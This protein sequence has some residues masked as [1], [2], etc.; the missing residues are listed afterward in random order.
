VGGS[1]V[2]RA[3]VSLDAVLRRPVLSAVD[4]ES[5]VQRNWGVDGRAEALPGERDRNFLVT[6]GDGRRYVLKVAGSEEDPAVI[7]CQV[8][9]VERLS[10]LTSYQWPEPVP[11]LAGAATVDV[12]LGGQRHTARLLTWVPG[13]PLA[14]VRPQRAGLLAETGALM[15]AV[16]LELAGFEHPGARRRLYWDPRLGCEVVAHCL[17]DVGDAHR[18]AVEGHMAAVDTRLDALA[19][20]PVGVI[21]GDGNDYNVLV[22]PPDADDPLAPRRVVGLVDMGDVVESWVA[23]DPAI[24]AAYAMLGKRDPL[25]AAGHVVK[26]YHAVR[27]LSE[28]EA[29]AIYPLILLRMCT[30]VCLAAHQRRLAPGDAYLSVSEASALALL[31]RLAGVSPDFACYALRAT[32]GFEPCTRGRQVGRWLLGHESEL[33]PIMHFRE[34]KGDGRGDP[35]APALVFDLGIG[36]VEVGD[37]PGRGDAD[38]WTSLLFD[39]LRAAGAALGVGRWDETRGWYTTDAYRVDGDDGPEWRSVHIGLDLFAPPGTEVLTP[40]DGVVHAVRDNAAPLDYGPTVVLEHVVDGGALRFHTL[41]GHLDPECLTRLGQGQHVQRGDLLARVGAPPRNGGWAP[42]VHVQVVADLL[43][44]DGEFPGVARPSERVIWRSLSPD[45]WPLTGLPRP[46][47][48]ARPGPPQAGILAARRERIGASL[49]VSYRRPLHIVR[50]WMQHLFDADGRRY[51]DAVNNV[52]HVG[53]CHP[54]VGRAIAEQAAVLNTNTRYLHELLVRYAERLRA[55]L[56]EPLC[57]CF[58]VC[59]GS[60]ANELALRL[61][62]AHTGRRDVVVLQGAYHGN[63]NTLIELSPYKY[64]GPGGAGPSPY[65]HEAAVPDPYRGRYRDGEGSAARYADDVARACVE[66]GA[67]GGVAAFFAESL[68]SCAGQIQPPDGYLAEAFRRVRNAGGVCVA[69]EVQVGLGRVGTHFWGFETQGAVPDIVTMGKPLGNGHP[70][71]AVVT[72]AAIASSFSNGMEY[73]NTFGGNPVSCAAGLAVLEVLEAEEL[74]R[75]ALV[76]GERLCR[77]L[78]ELASRHPLIGDIRGYGLFLGVEL[79]RDRGARTPAGPEATYVA[80][81]MRDRGIL[82]S[83]DGPD[84]NVLKLKPPL[85]FTADDA[86]RL[87]ETLDEVLGEDPVQRATAAG[88]P[89]V[90]VEPTGSRA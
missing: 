86:D 36:S 66:A 59:S 34:G 10:R 25:A 7:D 31:E 72:T 90:A 69:D 73:F 14:A 61:A 56:P 78:H 49:S 53:H 2:E 17:P 76:S 18:R 16:D 13:V 80:E 77:G 65:V 81:R 67:A 41:Y 39:R 15:G 20:L 70:L 43:G 45:P 27:P 8:Q 3:A 30:S 40:L 6:A 37:L 29:E 71:G 32:C 35:A 52:A 11:S 89:R 4:A 60:E 82:L 12:D 51:L 75:R 50:G 83:T 22:G 54:R 9:V 57:V 58:F 1:I 85:V 63:T 28:A 26:G 46:H 5:A 87:V 88:A 68:P 21:H 23:A 44:R 79:V 24:A 38:A 19:R 74:Q 47:D 33:G 55:T 48:A 42:H 64:R 62:R 84:H